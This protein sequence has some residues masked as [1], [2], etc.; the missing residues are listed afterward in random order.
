MYVLQERLTLY[1]RF[2]EK[3]RHISVATIET[4]TRGWHEMQWI[5]FNYID[6]MPDET[7]RHIF[8][9]NL[10]RPELRVREATVCE[11]AFLLWRVKNCFAVKLF[12]ELFEEEKT[13]KL[14]EE[15]FEFG[16]QDFYR[17]NTQ[18]MPFDRGTGGS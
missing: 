17:M 12:V 6:K 4:D 14:L 18:P 7:F 13:R 1:R 8:E 5:R 16:L 15:N 3:G 10:K 11:K 9:K 2:T